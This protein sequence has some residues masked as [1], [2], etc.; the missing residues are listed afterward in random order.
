MCID[1]LKINAIMTGDPYPIPHIEELISIIGRA[2][3]I[4]MLDLMKGYYQV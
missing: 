1:Y 3:F 2:T 4:S